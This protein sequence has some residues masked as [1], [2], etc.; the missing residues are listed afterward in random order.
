MAALIYNFKLLFFFLALWFLSCEAIKAPEHISQDV[1]DKVAPY[2]LPDD[3]PLKAAIDKIFSASRV[4]LNEQSILAA[5]FTNG[6]P[7]H[8]TH[9]IVNSH[10]ELPGLIFKM[11]MDA[12]PYYKKQTEWEH[13][14]N[15]IEGRNLAQ[16]IIDSKKWNGT[17]KTPKKWIY[18]LP[19]YPVPNKGYLRKDFILVEE[20]MDLISSLDNESAWG[21]ASEDFLDQFYTLLETGGFWDMAHPDNAWFCKDGRVA[22]IDTEGSQIWPVEY[23]KL[24]PYLPKRQLKYWKAL[25]K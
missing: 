9:V 17:F 10:R 14:V 18:M 4:I 3:H 23:Y 11:Y 15:R 13:F 12:Q 24:N 19:A 2:L 21:S 8:V 22:L 6:T 1:F 25:Y 16:E 5:G 20:R 7:R